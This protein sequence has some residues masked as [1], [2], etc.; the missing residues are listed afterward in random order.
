MDLLLR[1]KVLVCI[2]VATVW[3]LNV[4]EYKPESHVSVCCGYVGCQV[5]VQNVHVTGV[6]QRSCLYCHRPSQGGSS[7]W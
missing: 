6:V 5:F 1:V 7:S 4:I 2:L 3:H